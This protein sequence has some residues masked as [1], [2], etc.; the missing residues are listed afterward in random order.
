[1]NWRFPTNPKNTS[2]QHLS[3][4]LHHN[5]PSQHFSTTLY[6]ST[7]TQ[8][9]PTT[10]LHNTPSQHF[11]T[12][13]HHT[14]ARQH[15]FTIGSM[16][17]FKWYVAS[18][19]TSLTY[20]LL[21]DMQISRCQYNRS[22]SHWIWQPSSIPTLLHRC[23]AE[24][25]KDSLSN[26]SSGA[27]HWQCKR[28]ALQLCYCISWQVWWFEMAVLWWQLQTS[29]VE[30]AA[31]VVSVWRH[32]CLVDPKWQISSMETTGC[33]CLNSGNCPGQSTG[34]ASWIL[35]FAT[36]AVALGD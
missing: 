27:L 8:H 18:C 28:W 32:A 20:P 3:T 19:G 31:W 12:T 14:T 15:S 6:H 1:M 13:L 10:L 4:T 35:T 7:S 30:H 29:S 24:H 9:F 33:R 2:P 26:H 21:S 22:Y 36:F 11:S 17:P 16:A 5:T 23:Q 25:C 34:S